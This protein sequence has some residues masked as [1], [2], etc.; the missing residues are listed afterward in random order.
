VHELAITE[1]LVDL[2]AERAG[3]RRVTAVHVRVGALSGVVADAM[4]FCFDVV[5]AGTL[6]DGAALVLDEV[7]GRIA[8]RAC[9][10]ETG[11]ADRIRLCPCG[12]ADVDVVAGEELDV[13]FV[14]LARESSC[15]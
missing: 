10:R 9:G 11:V 2:V 12:S 14:E 7:P 8:C 15:A 6:L 13:A 4:A 3:G 1:S 5:A